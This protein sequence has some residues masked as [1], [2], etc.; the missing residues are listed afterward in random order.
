[1]NDN[2]RFVLGK[3]LFI[4]NNIVRKFRFSVSILI[5]GHLDTITMIWGI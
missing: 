1:M 5:Y 3:E 4:V 2:Y